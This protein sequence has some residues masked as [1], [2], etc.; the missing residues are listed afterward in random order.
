MDFLSRIYWNNN[1]RIYL[2]SNWL[3]IYEIHDESSNSNCLC[4][5][6][7]ILTFDP[8]YFVLGSISNFGEVVGYKS[9][10]RVK[11]SIPI[12]FSMLVLLLNILLIILV[13][14]S[15]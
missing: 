8:L 3:V 13:C 7:N 12:L 2:H 15:L 5:L 11:K 6:C 14:Y 9:V 10:F 1:I 4:F